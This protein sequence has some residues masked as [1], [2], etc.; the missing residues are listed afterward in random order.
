MGRRGSSMFSSGA[1]R[2][3]TCEGLEVCVLDQMMDFGL[4]ATG[5]GVR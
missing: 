1:R 5:D 4:H 3:M 2:W